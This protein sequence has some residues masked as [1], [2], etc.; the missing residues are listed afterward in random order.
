MAAPASIFIHLRFEVSGRVQGVFFRKCTKDAAKK[1]K[2][3]GWV[4]NTPRR[5]VIGEAQGPKSQIQLMKQWLEVDSSQIQHGKGSYIQ[6][7]QAKFKEREIEKYTFNTFVV[8][9]QG[10]Y[11]DFTLFQKK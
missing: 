9:K 11:E 1:L 5:T 6:V 10:T 3:V 7:E 2:L 4:Q 8:D